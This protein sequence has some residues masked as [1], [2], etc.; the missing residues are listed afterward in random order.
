MPAV[1]ARVDARLCQC[2]ARKVLACGQLGQQLLLQ[3]Q[4]PV[5]QDGPYSQ[6]VVQSNEQRRPQVDAAQLFQDTHGFAVPQSQATVFS[7]DLHAEQTLASKL[8]E[9]IGRHASTDLL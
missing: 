8:G 5:A 3:A 1:R 6:V 4:L 2:K 9:R 7:A